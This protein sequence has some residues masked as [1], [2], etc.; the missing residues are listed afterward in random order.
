[1][2]AD[3]VDGE[4]WL[5]A[6][7]LTDGDSLIRGQNKTRQTKKMDD[8]SFAFGNS[9]GPFSDL[10]S[11]V[12]SVTG[13]TETESDEDDYLTEL[14]RKIAQSTIQDSNYPVEN[15]KGWWVSGSP[16]STLCSVMDSCGCNPGSS[17]RSPNCFSKVS[18]PPVAKRKDS[19]T[20]L[21]LLSAAAEEVARMRMMEEALGFYST[22][23]GGADGLFIPPRKPSA[24]TVP[25]ENLNRGTGFYPNHTHLSFQ[26][27]QATEFQQLKESHMMKQPQ[28]G[29]WFYGQMKSGYKQMV[30]NNGSSI[31]S[32]MDAWSSVQQSQNHQQSGS[33]MKALF[34]GDPGTKKERTGT[35]V[36][37]PR[38]VG[39]PTET[40][41]KSVLSPDRVVQ[42]LNMNL[43]SMDSRPLQPQNR[44]NGNF[45]PDYGNNY[46][47]PFFS[48]MPNPFLL[49]EYLN[50]VC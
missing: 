10:S 14:T 28:Q 46:C 40:P 38:G 22:Y 45:I 49:F 15:N 43:K 31:A 19:T 32:S 9:F 39:G 20:S 13:S 11:P 34:L 48:I 33:G 26:R 2:A 16:Q 7:F 8:F 29:S 1:M 18:A 42:A 41:K 44:A 36:F 3:L 4:F 23:R 12:E 27:L 5:P 6:Q 30:Q 24:V 17:C 21:D 35:G 50:L 25:S 37:L 47:L